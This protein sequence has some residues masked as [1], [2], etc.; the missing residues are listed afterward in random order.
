[1]VGSSEMTYEGAFLRARIG[2]VVFSNLGVIW[3]VAK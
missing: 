2:F 1:M 3:R